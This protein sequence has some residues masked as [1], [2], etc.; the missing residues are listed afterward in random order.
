MISD[1]PTAS[2]DFLSPQQI[3]ALNDAESSENRIHSDDV[4][5]RY[6]FT[7]A[8]VSGVN[9]FGY[10]TQPLVRHYGAAFLERG[11][12]DVLF[13]KPAYQD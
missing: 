6:G 5:Q 4:A 1:I 2:T 11:M 8:L 7:G 10:L 9:I 3:L 12:M 13:L